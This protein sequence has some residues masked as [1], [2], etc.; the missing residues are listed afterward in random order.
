MD[1]KKRWTE[2]ED[3]LLREA[4]RLRALNNLTWAEV[5]RWMESK[6]DERTYTLSN[7]KGRTQAQYFVAGGQPAQPPHPAHAAQVANP[8]HPFQ[9]PAFQAYRLGVLPPPSVGGARLNLPPTAFNSNFAG[10]GHQINIYQGNSVGFGPALPVG[11]QSVGNVVGN[12][13][14]ASGS[15][16]NGSGTNGGQGDTSGG[17]GGIEED[18]EDHGDPLEGEFGDML[19]EIG[20]PMEYMED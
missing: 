1:S 8:A 17:N 13:V 10:L 12:G 9:V 15:G 18:G 3:T 2:E 6:S 4:L 20:Y 14:V 16:T 11:G 5:A 19:A 7:V